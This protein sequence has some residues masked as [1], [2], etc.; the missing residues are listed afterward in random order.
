M[1]LWKA[2]LDPYITT[3]PSS[4]LSVLPL[5]LDIPGFNTTAHIGIYLLTRGLEQ[6]WMIAMGFLSM[7]VEDILCSHPGIPI[8]IRG[9]A[10]SNP[11]HPSRPHVLQ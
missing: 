10:N 3:L 7:V 9:N 8:Y 6:E 11:N 1:A 4:L 5:I 2:S